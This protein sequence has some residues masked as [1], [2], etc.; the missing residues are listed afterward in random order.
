MEHFLEILRSAQKVAEQAEVFWVSWQ[1]TPVDF[2]ANKLKQIQHKESTGIALRIFRGGKIGFSAASGPHL[3]L[4]L[5]RAGRGEG[6][7]LL[8]MA[9]ETA[10]F[11]FPASFTFPSLRDYPE[12]N[13]FDPQVEKMPMEEMIELGTLTIAK[14][15]EYAPDILCDVRVTKGTGSVHI[16]NS[17]GG[18]ASYAKSFFS[19]NLEG[20]LIQDT[21]MLFVGDSE[22]SC[23]LPDKLDVVA[24]RVIRQLE[25][26]KENAAISGVKLLPVIFTPR[27]VASAFLSPIEVAF[28]GKAVLEGASKLRD[29][30]AEQVFDNGL[31]LW[32]DATIAYGIGSSPCDDEG[33]PSQCTA[34]IKNGVVSNFLYDLQTAA[35][36]GTQSTGNGRRAGASFPKPAISCLV[37]DEGEVPFQ[38][39][40]AD[41][42]EGLIVERLIGADQG[43]L[44]GGD[45]G[46]NVLLGY[47]VEN[48]K[49]VGRVKDTMISGKIYQVLKQLLGVGSE[50]RWVDG[51]LRTPHLYCSRLS[52]A[53]K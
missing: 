33:M 24:D 16:A 2:E 40:V 3:A 18:E 48:G 25:L 38:S 7:T 15:R 32:D 37:I 31:S 17:Q 39:M 14:V 28:N 13:I 47:K 23:C 44:L 26:A 50:A 51:V 6:E 11:G 41:M 10:Q 30:M 8:D 21:D 20:I 36:A 49:V 42:K 12:V 19:L 9:V 4:S 43:N 27:G 34:L 52:V 46:G 35:L 29:K 22:S 45:F 53:A 1:E 5:K